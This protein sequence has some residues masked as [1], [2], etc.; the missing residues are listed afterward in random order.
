[1][2]CLGFVLKLLNKLALHAPHACCDST[3]LYTDERYTEYFSALNPHK[4]KSR[5][6]L[7][8]KIP[9]KNAAK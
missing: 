7:A 8:L 6:K 2:V 9:A 5:T 4:K 1:M 3:H